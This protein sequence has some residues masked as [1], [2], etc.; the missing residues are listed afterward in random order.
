MAEALG[1]ISSLLAVGSFGVTLVKEIKSISSAPRRMR[2]VAR[3]LGLTND[4]LNGLKTMLEEHPTGVTTAGLESI[5]AASEHCQTVFNAID[6][7][8]KKNKRSSASSKNKI[9]SFLKR[10]A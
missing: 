6:I 5:K 3:E 10:G 4:A 7:V 2:D 1:V 9:F 8:L